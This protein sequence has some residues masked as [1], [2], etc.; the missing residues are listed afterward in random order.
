MST[1]PHAPSHGTIGKS[2]N[3]TENVRKYAAE[4]AISEEEAL[5]EAMTEKSK[6]FAEEAAEV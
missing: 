6:E 4:Q 2:V 3:I 5:V 1:H